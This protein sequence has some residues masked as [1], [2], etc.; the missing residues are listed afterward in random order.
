MTSNELC[1]KLISNSTHLF[2][3]KR[4]FKCVSINAMTVFMEPSSYVGYVRDSHCG[5]SFGILRQRS[6]ALY[7]HIFKIIKCQ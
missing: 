1:R 5:V 2:A 3:E 6:A 7:R 4:V